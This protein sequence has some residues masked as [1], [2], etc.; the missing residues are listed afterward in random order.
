MSGRASYYEAGIPKHQTSLHPRSKQGFNSDWG[1]HKLCGAPVDTLLRLKNSLN[2]FRVSDVTRPLGNWHCD[3]PQRVI[4][5]KAGIHWLP[6][7]IG[8]SPA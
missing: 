7:D 5:A 6:M 4:P 2:P 1:T 3:V 8:S